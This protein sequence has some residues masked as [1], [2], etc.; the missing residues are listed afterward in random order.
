VV[1]SLEVEHRRRLR[2]ERVIEVLQQLWGDELPPGP[3]STLTAVTDAVGVDDELGAADHL[4][5]QADGLTYEL[6]AALWRHHAATTRGTSTFL[7]RQLP[8]PLTDRLRSLDL[9]P[10]DEAVTGDQE[11]VPPSRPTTAQA[12]AL[13]GD[14]R[15][16]TDGPPRRV[17]SP[18]GVA[19]AVVDESAHVGMWEIDPQ[20]GQVAYDEVTARLIGAG[21]S[22]GYSSVQ[23][24]LHELV[25]P[26]DRERVEEAL[27]T[28]LTTGTAY[29]VRFRVVSPAGVVT[30]LVSHGRV[31]RK[32]SDRSGR[33]TGYLTVDRGS[34]HDGGAVA[35]GSTAPS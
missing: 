30:H 14:G 17:V 20:S 1:D 24:Q 27:H 33:L 15:G 31:L 11:T 22:H 35:R 9:L 13:A 26:A 7:A 4:V 21:T 29:L 18:H 10:H 19:E 6:L 32:P 34:S 5:G 3:N 8:W 28:A 23:E 25:H 16:A 12:A 2:A